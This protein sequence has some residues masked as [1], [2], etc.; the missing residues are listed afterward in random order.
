[1]SGVTIRHSHTPIGLC[2]GEL[3]DQPMLSPVENPIGGNCPQTLGTVPKMTALSPSPQ[4]GTSPNADSE[5]AFSI[6]GKFIVTRGL[7]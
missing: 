1:M 7:V 3:I 4:R 6:V 5:K 2:Q